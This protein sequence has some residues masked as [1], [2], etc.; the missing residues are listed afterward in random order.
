MKPKRN[1]EEEEDFFLLFFKQ[2]I[3]DLVHKRTQGNLINEGKRVGGGGG[4]R[5]ETLQ[6]GEGK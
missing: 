2:K 1:L 4:G 3:N 5:A 6:E